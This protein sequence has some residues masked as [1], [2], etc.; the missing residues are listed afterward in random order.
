MRTFLCFISDNAI[1]SVA[2]GIC[3]QDPSLRSLVRIIAQFLLQFRKIQFDIVLQDG[4][5]KY[6][7]MP[8][9]A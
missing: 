1:S 7:L 4:D 5:R 3:H 6:C 2:S 9:A 8:C